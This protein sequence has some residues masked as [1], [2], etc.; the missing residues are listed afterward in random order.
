MSLEPGTRSDV[1]ASTL[2]AR[3]YP[4]L[5]SSTIR[6]AVTFD[7]VTQGWQDFE[8]ATICQRCNRAMQMP[9]HS[10]CAH[11]LW[12]HTEIDFLD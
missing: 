3:V 7:H 4:Q 1:V 11:L 8:W 12:D 6:A 5:L 10:N 9:R 2:A